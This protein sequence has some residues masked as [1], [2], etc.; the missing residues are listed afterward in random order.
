LVY[1]LICLAKYDPSLRSSG[2][3]EI[4]SKF[5]NSIGNYNSVTGN[6]NEYSKDIPKLVQLDIKMIDLILSNRNETFEVPVSVLCALL[7]FEQS[8]PL[9]FEF[10]GI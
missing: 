4:S 6:L 7:T 2:T 3:I 1:H 5:I 8:A 10:N 9:N